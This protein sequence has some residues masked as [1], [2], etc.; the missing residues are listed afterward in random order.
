MVTLWYRPSHTH[1]IY[2]SVS[3]PPWLASTGPVVKSNESWVWNQDKI[4]L[5]SSFHSFFSSFSQQNIQWVRVNL[6]LNINILG[7]GNLA[8]S[9][10]DQYFKNTIFFQRVKQIISFHILNAWKY[11]PQ[12]SLFNIQWM[13]YNPSATVIDPLLF[14]SKT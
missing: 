10:V 6:L 7:N 8:A 5:S 13:W 1:R 2:V 9:K 3:N 4:L 11:K 12:N 14:I